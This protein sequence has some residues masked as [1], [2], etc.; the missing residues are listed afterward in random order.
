MEGDMGVEPLEKAVRSTRA[1]LGGVQPDQLTLSTPCASWRVSDLINH[2]VGGQFFFASM[3]SGDKPSR[4]RPDFSSGDFV[5][6]FERGSEA[7]IA[8]FSAPGAMERTLRLP[9]GE[10]PGAVFVRIAATDTFIHGWDLAKATGQPADLEPE[11]ASELL[12]GAR[13]V[14]S[15]SLRGPDGEAWFGPEQAASPDA[16]PADQLAA[17]LVRVVYI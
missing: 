7:S 11:L 16:T 9:F 6:D 5:G 14:L 4:D 1:V 12:A 10:L 3:A 8:A 17:F 13:T 15:D 2:I